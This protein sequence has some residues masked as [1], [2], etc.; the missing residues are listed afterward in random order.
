MGTRSLFCLAIGA[1]MAGAAALMAA[2]GQLR[3]VR[4]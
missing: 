2:G 1:L 3:D 4:R